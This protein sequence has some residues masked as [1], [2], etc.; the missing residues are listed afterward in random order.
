MTDEILE[1]NIS[2]TNNDSNSEYVNLPSQGIYYKGQ[3]K[4]LSKLLVRKLDYTDEDILTTK[5]YYDNGT[6]FTEILKNTI[7]EPKDFKAEDLV[8]VDRDAILWWLRK[9]TFGALYTT[10]MKCDDSNCKE[11]KS[12]S[13][14]WDLNSF[15]TPV[16]SESYSKQLVEEASVLLT[17]PISQLQCRITTPSVARE[18]QISDRLELKKSKLKLS[19]DFFNTGKLWS[20]ICEVFDKDGISL[21]TD[22]D[23][24]AQWLETGY[25]EKR[26]PLVDSRY[27]LEKAKII[28]LEIDTKQDIECPFCHTV[29]EG[30]KMP[31]K[32]EFFLP[33]YKK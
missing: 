33:D 11:K 32:I 18:K 26:L 29:Q 19:K 25:N 9:E 21:G 3:Y 4:G 22:T 14:T 1:E 15:E 31:L 8:P 7:L 13:I 20:V 5:S 16:L 6:I 17:L 24:I 2:S 10:S 23:I 12:F 30:I 28:S 27:I